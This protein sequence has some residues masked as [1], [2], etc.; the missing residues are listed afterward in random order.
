MSDSAPRPR[1]RG[2]PVVT[3]TAVGQHLLGQAILLTQDRANNSA[4]GATGPWYPANRITLDATAVR[5][6]AV[7]ERVRGEDSEVWLDTTVGEVGPLP[8]NHP[9]IPARDI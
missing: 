9:V 3:K 2:G 8:V 6:R 1:H 4:R 7:V 5:V